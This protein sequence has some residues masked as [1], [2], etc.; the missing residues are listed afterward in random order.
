[1]FR[2]SIAVPQ[3]WAHHRHQRPAATT[4]AATTAAGG[5]HHPVKIFCATNN[6]PLPISLR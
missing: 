2:V 6:S 5:R 3:T 1:M 4:A